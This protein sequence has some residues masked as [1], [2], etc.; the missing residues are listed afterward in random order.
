MTQV[1]L[2]CNSLEGPPPGGWFFG[3]FQWLLDLDLSHNKLV[4]TS[5]HQGFHFTLYTFHANIRLPLGLS[6]GGTL[7]PEICLLESLVTLNL[8]YAKLPK[9][10]MSMEI[11]VRLSPAYTHHAN[12]TRTLSSAATTSFTSVSRASLGRASFCASST[13]LGTT[14]RARFH[15]PSPA[16]PRS[17]PSS[18]PAT[19]CRAS[20]HRHS[21]RA[22]NIA[23]TS[24]SL[25]FRTTQ[26]WTPNSAD[27]AE[28]GSGLSPTASKIGS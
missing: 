5:D 24:G 1:I 16:S 26:G 21:H 7:S 11:G 18:W 9:V 27:S 17:N 25:T 14:S 22:S 19:T 15:H 20:S 6:Q 2:R 3:A 23:P 8:R 4:G 12:Y 13:S 10:N 28:L